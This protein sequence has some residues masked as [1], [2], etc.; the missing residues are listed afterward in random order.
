MN[1]WRKKY[2]MIVLSMIFSS[3]SS[4][5]VHRVKIMIVIESSFYEYLSMSNLCSSFN[6]SFSL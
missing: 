1:L 6:P 4:L 5:M 3:L 2:D